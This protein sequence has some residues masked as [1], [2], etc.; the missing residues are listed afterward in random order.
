MCNSGHHDLH[1]LF[2]SS[3]AAL[4]LVHTL[5]PSASGGV[6]PIEDVDT[7]NTPIPTEPAAHQQKTTIIPK[8]YGKIIRDD[9]GNVVRIELAEGEEEEGMDEDR[10]MDMEELE[11]EGDEK[12]LDKWVV[13]LGG[14]GK[15]KGVGGNVVQGEQSLFELEMRLVS[16]IFLFPPIFKVGVGVDCWHHSS[17][18]RGKAISV[19]SA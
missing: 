7:A 12:V 5:N 11:P 9:D 19:L 6:E 1:A 8:G 14:G 16:G 4:G 15:G 17:I 2:T 18:Y 3:Y 10:E 13:E